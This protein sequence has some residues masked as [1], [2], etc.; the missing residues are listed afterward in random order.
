MVVRVRGIEIVCD[1]LDELDAIIDRYGDGAAVRGPGS[2][3]SNGGGGTTN[4]DGALLRA[5]LSNPSGVGSPTIQGMLKVQ[6]K[7]I[8]AALKAWA[9][10]MNMPVDGFERANPG[11][12]RGWKLND[13]AIAAGKLLHSES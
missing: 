1:S 10:R 13:G 7:A 4:V 6:G 5:F 12:R 11:G 3:S 2:L 9:G 8:S